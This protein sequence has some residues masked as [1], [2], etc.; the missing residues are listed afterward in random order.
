MTR[1]II[2]P[3]RVDSNWRAITAELDAPE[4][5]RVEAM[6]RRLGVPASTTRLIAA[7]PAL[8]R[9]WY[10]AIGI[11]AI[12]GLG[13]AGPGDQASLFALLTLAPTL[14]VLGVAL[15]FGPSSDPMYEAQLATP[16]RG[17]RLVA[18]RAATVLAVDRGDRDTRTARPRHPADGCCMAASHAGAH[19]CHDGH[20]GHDDG[21][22]AT[23]VSGGGHGDLVRHRL[24]GAGGRVG[25]SGS[26]RGDR[27]GRCTGG[28]DRCGWC[29]R[30]TP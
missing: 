28:G 10:L 21:A 1:P 2:D 29:G 4:P 22:H 20:V 27:P 8:R 15:A 17:I 23:A 7:T 12:V 11:P 24:R 25:E 19:A 5:G 26:V 9:S 16:T 6:L 13:A 30:R 3:N 14:P 18:I